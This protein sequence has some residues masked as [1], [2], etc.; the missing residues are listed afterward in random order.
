MSQQQNFSKQPIQDA[1]NF[2][3]NRSVL[4]VGD[5]QRCEFIP[6][7]T[8]NEYFEVNRMAR[9][10]N[11][12]D[13]VYGEGRTPD[14]EDIYLSY[15]RVF[16]ILLEV[17]LGHFI[18]L[19]TSSEELNDQHLPFHPEGRPST[20]P[21]QQPDFFNIFC[22]KQWKFCA[23]EFSASMLNRV[24]EVDRILPIVHQEEIAGSGSALL[25]KI[26]IHGSYNKLDPKTKVWSTKIRGQRNLL[27]LVVGFERP[28][29]QHVRSQNI[30]QTISREILQKWSGYFEEIERNI[31]SKPFD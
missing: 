5:G 6:L 10:H 28:S 14:A 2:F 15:I 11:L 22:E 4:A 30:P 7:E 16:C 21:K 19:F 25:Y 18:H 29:C 1:L 24:F 23:A 20:F 27:I 9:L 8:L 13:A 26:R 3:R 12:L 31:E 17:G